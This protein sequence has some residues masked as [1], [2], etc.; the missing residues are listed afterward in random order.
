MNTRRVTFFASSGRGVKRAV[1][2]NGHVSHI[3]SWITQLKDLQIIVHRSAHVLIAKWCWKIEMMFLEYKSRDLELVLV[4]ALVNGLASM[5]R[6]MAGWEGQ[7][8]SQPIIANQKP[9]HRHK[10][11]SQ[12]S[13]ARPWLRWR[14]SGADL[15]FDLFTPAIQSF[16]F[17]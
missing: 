13:L 10:I 11:V 5:K 12:A 7:I 17:N 9:L 14:V 3:S 1:E 6:S 8:R 2:S 16:P 15:L 4:R